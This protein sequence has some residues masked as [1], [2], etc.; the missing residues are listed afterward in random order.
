LPSEN[1]HFSLEGSRTG[2]SRKANVSGRNRVHVAPK[3]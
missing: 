1:E 2:Q 3:E